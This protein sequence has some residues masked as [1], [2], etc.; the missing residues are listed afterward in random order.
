MAN[1]IIETVKEAIHKMSDAEIL[2]AYKEFEST[3]ERLG[4]ALLIDEIEARH[5]DTHRHFY[6]PETY[7]LDEAGL[8]EE[9]K[10][11]QEETRC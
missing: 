7:E 9:L 2:E 6:N 8:I 4:K 11:R 10:S 5:P 3:G 1:P